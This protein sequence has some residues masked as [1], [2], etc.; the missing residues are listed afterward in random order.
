MEDSYFVPL[1][2]KEEWIADVNERKAFVERKGL[3]FAANTVE[4][5]AVYGS[6]YYDC[7]ESNKCVNY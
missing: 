3:E 1:E 4:Q 5:A 6:C 7:N 2:T